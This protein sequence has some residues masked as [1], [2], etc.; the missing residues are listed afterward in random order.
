LA[1]TFTR[2]PLT[3]LK[4]TVSRGVNVTCWDELP[5]GGTSVG[6]LQANV[7]AMLAEPLLSVDLASVWPNLIC[8]ALGTLVIVGVALTMVTNAVEYEKT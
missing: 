3:A 6:L 1:C 4:S 7:P 2:M 5:L 8:D